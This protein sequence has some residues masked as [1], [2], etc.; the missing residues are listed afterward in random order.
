MK[1]TPHG[2]ILIEVA[3]QALVLAEQFRLKIVNELANEEDDGSGDYV[4]ILVDREDVANLEAQI[5]EIA[6]VCRS[7]SDAVLVEGGAN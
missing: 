1:L 5:A 2:K 4:Y 3:D 6:H 7:L